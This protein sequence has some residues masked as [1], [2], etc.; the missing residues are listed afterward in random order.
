MKL[1][2]VLLFLGLG[3]QQTQKDVPALT[4]LA[5]GDSYTIG[6]SV[7]VKDRWP[8]QLADRLSK[9][10]IAIKQP[11]IVAKTGWTTDELKD[12]IR[13]ST[14][15]SHYDIVS[16]LIG[17][18]NQYRG[19]SVSEFAMQFNSLLDTCLQYSGGQA[20]RVFVVSIPD[21][22]AMPFAEGRDREKIAAEID[23]FNQVKQS[24]S[25][26]RGIHFIDITPISRQATRKSD[27]VAADLLHPS[28]AMYQAWVEIIFPQ[29]EE[30]LLD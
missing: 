7:A 5:L 19:R 21:W 17:V 25:A 14:L 27:Y 11:E 18:N 28:A 10:G 2:A 22:G 1:L 23:H 15:E 24:E 12:G 20:D 8:V 3:C 4:Y 13:N 6:E 29:V 30:K 26:K 16:L 9:S